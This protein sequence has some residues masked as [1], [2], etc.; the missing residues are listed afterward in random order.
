MNSKTWKVG[1]GFLILLLLLLS[2]SIGVRKWIRVKIE[3][4]IKQNLEKASLLYHQ[5]EWG[6]TLRIYEETLPRLQGEEKQ[7]VL[8]RCGYIYYMKGEYDKAESF[9]EKVNGKYEP[10][11][12]FYRACRKEKEG[13]EEEALRLFTLLKEKFPHSPFVPMSLLKIA[14]IKKERGEWEESR[15]FLYLL[16]E[17]YKDSGYRKEILA[18]LGE[19]NTLLFFSSRPSSESILYEVKPG[20]SLYRIAKKFNTTTDFLMKKN[21]LSSALI[22]P[23]QKLQVI[24]GKFSIKINLR[25]NLLYLFYEGKIFKVYPVATGKDNSTPVGK[26]VV[27]E[28][29]KNPVWYSEKG[30]IPPGSPE[31]VLGSRW[32]GISAPGIGIHEAINPQDVGKYVSNGCI[33]MFKKDV[34]ELYDLI[35]PGTSVVIVAS[36][37]SEEDKR[38]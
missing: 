2:L 38:G 26:F 23:G 37:K 36:E 6:E 18:L 27:T 34:E 21:N 8:F 35:T 15:N 13:H 30:P 3:Q 9:W 17:E 7:E 10:E 11:I 22:K 5:G 20:D 12:L 29:L 31:N 25:E 1:I 32:I 4:K 16:W 19:V 28:K 24:P 33:R 14:K